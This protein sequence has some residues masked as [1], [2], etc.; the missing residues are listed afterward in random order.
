M[1]DTT[2][3]TLVDV[4]D[5][6]SRARALLTAAFVIVERVETWNLD[7]AETKVFDAQRTVINTVGDILENVIAKLEVVKGAVL[8]NQ[9]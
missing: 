6:L 8:S 7:P 5:E 1:T 3:T 4:Q 9:R 2:I